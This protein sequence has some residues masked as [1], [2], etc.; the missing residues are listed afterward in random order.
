VTTSDEPNQPAPDP[1]SYEARRLLALRY[2]LEFAFADD[3]AVEV[4]LTVLTGGAVV[5]G[6]AVSSGP[7]LRALGE[8]IAQIEIPM[9]EGQD[10]L[11]DLMFDVGEITTRARGAGRGVATVHVHLINATVTGPDGT[12]NR[13]APQIWRPCTVPKL[14]ARPATCRLTRQQAKE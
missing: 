12:P 3:D 9:S 14:A 10:P 5:S 13:R 11:A 4:P 8:Q 2:I 7:W 1:M 6:K